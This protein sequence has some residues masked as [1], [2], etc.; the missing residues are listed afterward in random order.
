MNPTNANSQAVGQ[1]KSSMSAGA[2]TALS[3]VM[4]YPVVYMAGISGAQATVVTVTGQ[5]VN[6][7]FNYTTPNATNGSVGWNIDGIGGAEFNLDSCAG[8]TIFRLSLNAAQAGS[9]VLYQSNAAASGWGGN[10]VVPVM[11]STVIGPGSGSFGSIGCGLIGH[12]CNDSRLGEWGAFGSG[13][14]ANDRQRD[15]TMI[16]GFFGF[17]FN[18][19]G[20]T[21]YGVAHF[22]GRAAPVDTHPNQSFFTINSWA[23]QDDGQALH[24]TAALG[25]GLRGLSVP[26]PDTLALTLFGL[27]AG[28]AGIR[29][30][31]SVRKA[32]QLH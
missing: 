15:R 22:S 20:T 8:T 29:R 32:L 5:P 14:T 23:Y 24:F 19:A 25:D 17:R 9:G 1:L 2:K 3:H 26:E 18:N 21:N 11:S 27:A 16:E 4:L 31:R 13:A 10:D 28:A 6:A 7:L 30:R 12:S